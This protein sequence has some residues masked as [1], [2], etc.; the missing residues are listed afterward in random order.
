M[1]NENKLKNIC[2]KI[3]D[4]KYKFFGIMI[5]LLTIIGFFINKVGIKDWLLTTDKVLCLWTNFKFF[6]M[7]LASYELFLIITNQNKK[8]S[9]AGTIVLAFSGYT[10]W[11][12][13]KYDSLIF[14]EIITVL[15]YGIITSNS[16]RNDILRVIGI[17]GCSIGYM[18]AFRPFAIAF[19]YVFFALIIWILLENRKRIKENKK[20]VTLGI[21]IVLGVIFAIVTE[22]F[23]SKYYGDNINSL[24]VGFSGLFSY[25]Y[26]PLL[27][28][29]NIE[30]GGLF[31]GIMS[32]APIPMFLALYYI[33]KKE[34]HTSFLLPIVTVT[35]LETI[36][37]ISGFPKM[38]SN[39][40]FLSNVSAIRVVPAVQIANLFIIFYF[41]ANV[42]DF[43]L[44]IKYSIRI[45][46]LTICVLAFIQ[47]PT[48]FTPKKYLYLFVA[49]LCT[50]VF[51][52]LN[53]SNEK[54]QKV[55][56]N[57]LICLSL[58]SAIPVFFLI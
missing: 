42:D 57:I 33:Y 30:N 10:V 25:L 45:T 21:T 9:G 19:G 58:V 49:E 28:F 31:G 53:Y 11:N 46:I 13:T 8:L 34:K 36:Y 52:F 50:I 40:T 6:A 29:Y 37:C 24:K 15:I 48:A 1:K 43:S 39:F 5:V 38:I 2:N 14:A 23:F 22:I 12:Y 55:F 20:S 17:L 51:M 4:N 27:P 16:T 44:N 18:Y 32:L 26:N 41:L 54:Y 35:V 3:F 56:I 47:Y 7:L